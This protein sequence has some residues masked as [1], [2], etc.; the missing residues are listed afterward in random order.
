MKVLFKESIISVK[1]NFKR[2]LSILLIVLLGVVFFVGIR[3][4]SPNMKKTLD[5]YYEDT[6]F[7]DLELLSTW[8]IR[9]SDIDTIRNKGYIV[10]AYYQFDAIVEAETEEVIKIISYD[11]SSKMNKP[12]LL[13]GKFPT[14]KNECVIE[15]SQYTDSFKI[16]DTITVKTDQLKEKK[17]TVVG[18]I[19]SPIYPSIERGTTT[20]LSGRINYFMYVPLSNFDMDYYTNLSVDLKTDLSTFSDE[21]KKL[22]TTKTDELEKIIEDLVIERYNEEV[23]KANNEIKEQEEKLT[24]EKEKYNKEIQ[25]AE[26]ELKKGLQ[27]YNDNLKKLNVDAKNSEELFKSSYSKLEKNKQQLLNNQKALESQKKVFQAKKKE[28]N[29]TLNELNKN[30]TTL[31]SKIKEVNNNI[32]ELTSQ[33]ELLEELIKTGGEVDTNQEKLIRVES[34]ITSLN[35]LNETLENQLSEVKKNIDEISSTITK[36]ETEINNNER[37]ITSSLKTI[38]Q[39]INE[40]KLAEKNAIIQIN[41]SRGQL[42]NAYNSIIKNKTKLENEKEEAKKQFEDAQIQIKNAKKEVEKIEKPTWYVLDRETNLGFYQYQQDSDRIAKIGEVFPLVFF[43]VAILICLTSI[44]RMVEEERSQLGTLKALGYSNLQIISKYINYALLAT[45]IG[46]ILGLLIGPNIIPRIIYNMYSTMYYNTGELVNDFNLYHSLTGTILAIISTLVA[47]LFACYKE[48]KEVPATLMRPKAP[49][50][51]KRV[52]LEKIPFIWKR[53]SFTKKVTVRNVFRHKKRFLMT[54][55][56]VLGCTGL[57]IAG[58]G[59]K[60][61]ITAMAPKQYG[62]IFDYDME[63]VFKDDVTLNEKVSEIQRIRN[64]ED[65]KKVVRVNKTSIDLDNKETNQTI[66][67]IVPFDDIDGF[68]NLKNRTTQEKYVLHNN[69]I[70]TE[71][72]ANLLKV[73]IGDKLVI[74]NDGKTYEVMIDK[75]TE[76]YFSHYIYMDQKI[77]DSSYYNTLLIKTDELTDKEKARVSDFLRENDKFASITFSESMSSIFDSTMENF[78]L[79]T[80]VLIVSAGLLAIVVLYNLANVNISER[81]RELA[82]IKVLGFTDKEVYNYIERESTILT[83]IGMI[84]GCL[85]GKILTLYILKTC[86]LDSIMFATTINF[87][88]YIYSLIITVAF[89]IVVNITTYFALKKVDMIESLKSVE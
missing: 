45:I 7:F 85:M 29:A 22:I 10:E 9:D 58:F 51:G 5:K 41:N 14:N 1:K 20:L 68:I 77:Y 47:T 32:K 39:K 44:T 52:F 54:I 67:L 12:V 64:N 46:S 16:G 79:V 75:I 34:A 28:L 13:E 31:L 23:E 81:K 55:I 49:K 66:Q 63:I 73:N 88:S 48:L 17:L 56:G 27:Q 50:L 57:I 43:V 74:N 26:Q 33:K 2:F 53:L 24:K 59:L 61:C 84:L 70:I 6:T 8:G 21:Y 36:T 30:Q 65:I 83:I 4:T 87:S 71:K 3:V 86:E 38:D 69:V 72:I 42:N 62:E 25:K 80:S 82:T 18:I 19:K 35:T 78:G 89:T 40:L 11:E 37:I 15:K 60:D 76:N